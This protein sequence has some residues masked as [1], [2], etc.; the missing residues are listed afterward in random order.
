M[1]IHKNT[2]SADHN[3]WLK[4]LD[5]Q[6]DKPTNK[7][8]IKVPKIVMLTNK[9]TLFQTLRTSVINCDMCVCVPVCVIVCVFVCVCVG[10]PVIFSVYTIDFLVTLYDN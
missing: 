8:S 7:N 9:K 4:R 10:V 5:T 6:S 3:R 2:P 1:I